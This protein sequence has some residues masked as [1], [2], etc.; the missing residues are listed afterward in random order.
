VES[1]HAR[2][3]DE[4][5][6]REE[7]ASLSQAKVLLEIWRQ[8]YNEERPHGALGYMTPAAFAESCRGAGTGFAALSPCQHRDEEEL[9][10]S[11]AR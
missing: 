1:Y 10:E 4:L 6:D 2:L 8:E 11:V 5:L 9:M 7:F 3:R